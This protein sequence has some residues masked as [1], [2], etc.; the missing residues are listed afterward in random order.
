[1]NA[2]ASTISPWRTIKPASRKSSSRGE[3]RPGDEPLEE[4]GPRLDDKSLKEDEVCFDEDLL[5]GDEA[6]Y[7]DGPLDKDGASAPTQCDDR[8]QTKDNTQPYWFEDYE[9]DEDMQTSYAR[10]PRAL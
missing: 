1:M 4:A 10:R 9:F 3:A 8:E 2:F 5:E 6:R 7:D